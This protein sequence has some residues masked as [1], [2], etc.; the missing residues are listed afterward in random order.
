[1]SFGDGNAAGSL[2]TTHKAARGCGIRALKFFF[3]VLQITSPDHLDVQRCDAH[4]GVESKSRTLRIK[5]Y[6]TSDRSAVKIHNMGVSDKVY[7]IGLI[8]GT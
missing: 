1:M 8:F 3:P 6:D 7:K 5:I 2:E 4:E